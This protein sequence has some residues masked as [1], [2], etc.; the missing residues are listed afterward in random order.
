[1]FIRIASRVS[2][3]GRRGF[4]RE[5]RE[6]LLAEDAKVLFFNMEPFITYSLHGFRLELA[7][8]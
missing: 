4:S 3:E 7:G 6:G 8:I 1:L 5:G 2:R